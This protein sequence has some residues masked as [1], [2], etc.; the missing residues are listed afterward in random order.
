MPS[1]GISCA[2]IGTATPLCYGYVRATG[3]QFLSYTAPD[4]TEYGGWLLGEGEWDGFDIMWN[5][6]NNCVALGNNPKYGWPPGTPYIPQGPN[7]P[8]IHFHAGTDTPIGSPITPTSSGPDQLCDSFWGAVPGAA[9]ALCLSGYAY[10]MM[11]WLPQAWQKGYP[12]YN[13]A[14]LAPVADWRSTKCRIFD[15]YGNQTAYGFTTNPAWHFVDSWIRVGILPRTEYNISL[16][17]GPDPLPSD[18]IGRFDWT[19]IYAASQYYAQT[20]AN[21]APRF[22]GS[23]AFASQCTLQAIQ[24]QILLCCRSYAPEPAYAGK[25]SLYC[26]Q[27]RSSV[28][29][30]SGKHLVPF[31]FS[32]DDKQVN[33]NANLYEG[34]FLDLNE[35]TVCNVASISCDNSSPNNKALITTVEDNPCAQWDTISIGG[36][37][38]PVLNTDYLVYANT[39][40]PNQ[41]LAYPVD[42]VGVQ[43]GTGGSVGYGIARF[44]KRSPWLLHQAHAISQGEM[45]SQSQGGKARKKLSVIF[46]FANNTF[47]QVNRLLKYEIYRDLGLDPIGLNL[48]TPWTPPIQIT[49]R[50]WSESVDANLSVLKRVQCGKLI[51]IDQSCSWEFAGVYEVMERYIFPFQSDSSNL[52]GYID[53]NGMP[54]GVGTV[55]KARSADS[56]TLELVLRTYNPNVFFDSSDTPAASYATVPGNT[57]WQGFGPVNSGYQVGYASLS[58][59]D[60][61]SAETVT[62]TGVMVQVGG[63]H[64]VWE[65][66]SNGDATFVNQPY[67][68]QLYIYVDDPL[69]SGYQPLEIS[70][71]PGVLTEVFGRMYVGT[72]TTGAHGGGGGTGGGGGG[73]GGPICFKLG[74]L[75]HLDTAIVPNTIAFERWKKGQS[76]RLANPWGCEQVERFAWRQVDE[77]VVLAFEG[78]ELQCSASTLLWDVELGSWVRAECVAAGRS[79]GFR[80]CGRELLRATVIKE[81]ALVLEV[82]LHGPVSEYLVGDSG[83]RTHNTKF[84]N[85]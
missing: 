50:A 62:I 17:T 28:F 35:P 34:D 41:I 16:A 55:A 69:V 3:M 53:Q 21:G 33:Q 57:L 84:V 80:D 83:L 48:G 47:D 40:N 23:Y 71:N 42:N 9:T 8:T 1:K 46:D 6:G 30:L 77:L 43:S 26:D 18:V 22:C 66:D 79:Y 39:A 63:H 49:L 13:G 25:I 24:E 67:S 20:L 56:G 82:K 60:A 36:N 72:I 14:T 74:T 73:S 32:V 70:S 68:T 85:A 78:E 64:A 59:A 31:T 65:G 44:A 52:T 58:S 10:Y 19:S 76:V 51:T 4:G 75:M 12:G 45:I 61:G 27:P 5:A 29:T 7:P 2:Q 15:Q 11:S 38:N 54:S 81:R 37:S